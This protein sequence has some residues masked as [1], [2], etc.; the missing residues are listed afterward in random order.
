MTT[1]LRHEAAVL[2]DLDASTGECFGDLVIPYSRL[3]PD[4]ARPFGKHGIE[5]ERLSGGRSGN[6]SVS[7]SWPSLRISDRE[8]SN[9]GR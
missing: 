2:Y 5:M 9:E 1:M 3:K 6:S 4:D 7:I 8:R